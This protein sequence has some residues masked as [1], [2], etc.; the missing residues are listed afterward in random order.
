MTIQLYDLTCAD[1]RV[2]YSPFCWRTRMALKHKGL[3]FESVPWHFTDTDVLAPSGG[4]RVP[5]IVDG[6]KWIKESWDIAEY[7]DATYPD[8]PVLLAD[9]AA[10]ARAKFVESW[11]VSTLFPTLRP[12]AVP[13]VFE[14]I[15][16]KDRAYF[17][18]SRERMLG[19]MD[20]WSTD[21]EGELKAFN[22]AL[23]PVEAA[24]AQA[25]FLAGETPD[26]ADYILFGTLMWPDMVA[27]AN[28]IQ[29]D[30]KV[31][32]WFERMLDLHDS[33]ARNAPRAHAR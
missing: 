7:L 33:Y 1:K 6:D 26:Y 13:H 4:G 31:R 19:P 28:P 24:V 2:F 11:C 15:A 9:A 3:P 21:P 29:K 12:L 8:R 23:A 5:V 22:A 20:Q 27:P 30:T 25:P 32:A 17:K 14:I 10:R 18:E 16:E